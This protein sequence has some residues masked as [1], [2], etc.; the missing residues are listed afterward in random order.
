LTP[1]ERVAAT[2]NAAADFFDHPALGFWSYYG[3]RTCSRARIQP[4]EIVLDVCSG[5][6]ASAIPAARSAAPTGRVIGLDIAQELIALARSKAAAEG[7]ANIEFRHADF[8]QAYFRAASFDVVQCCFGV[9][10]FPDM[11][12]TLQKMWRLL[13]PG[14]RLSIVTWGPGSFEPGESAFW[15]AVREIRPDLERVFAPWTKLADPDVLRQ[16]FTSAGISEVEIETEDRDHSLKPGDWWAIVLGSGYR[17]TVEQLT[18]EQKELLRERM[19]QS[20]F[21]S[22]RTPANYALAVR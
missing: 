20:E 22:I 6:G 8:D 5:S 1:K 9:F 19:Q 17:A 3:E 4:G 7:L 13:R 14:G 21:A 11:R 2:Y 18:P 16:L 12:A 15:D 10:F